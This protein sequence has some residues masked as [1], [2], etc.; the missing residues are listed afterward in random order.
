M[1][2]EFSHHA[3]VSYWISKSDRMNRD[4][5]VAHRQRLAGSTMRAIRDTDD[6]LHTDPD[7]VP[8]IASAFYEDLFTADPVT[9]EILDAREH[10]WS[11]THSR[12]I[13]LSLWQRREKNFDEDS[14]SQNTERVSH[15][16]DGLFKAQLVSFMETFQQLAKHLKMQELLQG[17]TEV[18]TLPPSE[19]EDSHA[20]GSHDTHGKA[21]MLEWQ[22]VVKTP[23]RAIGSKDFVVLFGLS[24]EELNVLD[25]FEDDEYVRRVVEPQVLEDGAKVQAYTYVWADMHDERLFG[26]WNYEEWRRLHFEDFYAMSSDFANEIISSR[27][28]D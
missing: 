7:Q 19:K 25:D 27:P 18:V 16:E 3:S 13:E 22:Q 11:V 2:S 10:I 12:D 6:V 23:S 15:V 4:F 9:V 24:G 28:R 8:D 21:P 1:R 14:S 17:P 5:F 26:D 20:K